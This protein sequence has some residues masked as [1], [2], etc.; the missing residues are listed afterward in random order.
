MLADV[1]SK[2]EVSWTILSH[3][4]FK[5]ALSWQD[6]G[7]KMPKMSQDRRSWEEN[8]V[9]L[10]NEGWSVCGLL[11]ASGRASGGDIY[12]YIYIYTHIYIYIYIY[13]YMYIYI[14]IYICT[15]IHIYIYTYIHI[16][17]YT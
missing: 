13:I 17:I 3:L 2:L 9:A 10:G 16:Y 11:V 1:G 15:Y 12:I 14:Y 8:W 7:T 5:L 6:V 4:G